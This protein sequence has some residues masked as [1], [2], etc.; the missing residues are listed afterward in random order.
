[1]LEPRGI[2]SKGVWHL[3]ACSSSA[4]STSQRALVQLLRQLH[5]DQERNQ[6]FHPAAGGESLV[7]PWDGAGDSKP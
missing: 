7:S 1:M 6:P 4:M 2:A 3:R 5:C